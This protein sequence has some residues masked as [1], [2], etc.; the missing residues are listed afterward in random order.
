MATT[1]RNNSPYGTKSMVR[2]G[3]DGT[4]QPCSI[5]EGQETDFKTKVFWNFLHFNQKNLGEDLELICHILSHKLFTNHINC[6]CSKRCCC[7]SKDW[8]ELE[9]LREVVMNFA[10]LWDIALCRILPNHP[11]EGLF[12]AQ[13]IF[14]PNFGLYNDY[15]ALYPRRWRL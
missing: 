8:L 5:F 10:I 3:V 1:N 9:V 2:E 14:D 7:V 13:L 15:L 11:L 12:L 6:I 4:K